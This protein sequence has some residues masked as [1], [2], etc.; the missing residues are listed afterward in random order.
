MSR[1]FKPRPNN[2]FTERYRGELDNININ[3]FIEHQK[4]ISILLLQEHFCICY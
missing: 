2:E 1:Q 4:D 3:Q